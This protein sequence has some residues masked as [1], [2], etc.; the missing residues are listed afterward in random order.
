MQ[1]TSKRQNWSQVGIGLFYFFWLHTVLL[2]QKMCYTNYCHMLTI[3]STILLSVLIITMVVIECLNNL[4]SLRIP[5]IL[6]VLWKC[7]IGHETDICFW[8]LELSNFRHHNKK[9]T[10][11]YCSCT[12]CVISPIV[13]IFILLFTKQ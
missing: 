8:Q 12:I 11:T 10:E 9:I 7:L 4:L 13:L 3:R 6:T 1:F 2:K 5:I